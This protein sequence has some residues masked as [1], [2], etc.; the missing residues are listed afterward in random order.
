MRTIANPNLKRGNPATE[1]GRGLD[2]VECCAKANEAKRRNYKRKSDFQEAAKWALDMK[3]DGMI[4]GKKVKITQAQAIVLNLLKK[5]LSDKDKQA[6]EAAKVLI[7]LSGANRSN[8]EIKLLEAQA[9]KIQAEVDLMTGADTSA[10]DKLDEILGEMR[11]NA[12][13]EPETE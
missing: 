7:Q 12:D 2:A 6:I 3:T 5:S 11:A 13:T 1:F 8:A 4:N 10:L 9:A